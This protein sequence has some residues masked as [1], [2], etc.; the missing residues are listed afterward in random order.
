MKGCGEEGV[1]GQI[2]V[3]CTA[4]PM[5]RCV[6]DVVLVM[7]S[8]SVPRAYAEDVYFSGRGFSVDTYAPPQ[9]R[10]LR[11]GVFT[12][13]KFATPAPPCLRAVKEAADALRAAGHEVVP[14][15]PS[16]DHGLDTYRAACN[17]YAAMAADGGMRCYKDALAGELLLLLLLLLPSQRPSSW[18]SH[19]RTVAPPLLACPPPLYCRVFVSVHPRPCV[20]ACVCVQASP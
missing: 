4:G 8:W 15:R 11:I 16:E 13:D 14:W 18:S 9:P 20:R 12:D 5:G 17:Y 3:P 1:E 19:A 6:D 10:R 7:R 2:L